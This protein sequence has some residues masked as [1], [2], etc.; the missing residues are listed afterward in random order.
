M[1]EKIGGY[2]FILG[3]I[4]AVIAGIAVGVNIGQSWVGWVPLILFIIGIIVGL[5]NI[6]DKEITPFLIA[7]IALMLTYS[8]GTGLLEINKVLPSVGTILQQIVHHVVIL[9]APAALIIGLL[10]FWKIAST[11]KG[12][13]K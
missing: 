1:D 2:A 6:G 12:S 11:P 7:S 3:V 4:I 8:A 9:V 5:L 13:T 10:E